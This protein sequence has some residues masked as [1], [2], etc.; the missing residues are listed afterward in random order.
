M[1]K[2]RGPLLALGLLMLLMLVLTERA[3]S[4]IETRT[5]YHIRFGASLPTTCKPTTGDVF[6]KTAAT[7]GVYSC[8]ATD[9]WTYQG[10]GAGGPPTG[11]AGGDLAGTYPNPTL[12]STG[13]TPATYGSATQAVVIVVDAKGR[14]TGASNVTISGVA[15]GG[16]A[17]GELTGNYPNPTLTTSGASAGTYGAAT[18]AIVATVDAKGR[19]TNVSEVTITGVVPG[20]AA[21]GDLTGTYPNPTL[22][23]SGVVAGTYGSA[24]QVPVV[25]VDAKGRITGVSNVTISGVAPGGA[26]GGQ[27]AGTYPNPTLSAATTGGRVI[28]ASGAGT[29][30][31]QSNFTYTNGQLITNATTP[32]EVMGFRVEQ[33][34]K[35][36]N[37]WSELVGR[38]AGDNRKAA[39]VGT[40]GLGTVW[41]AG[42]ATPGT[43]GTRILWVTSTGVGAGPGNALPSGTFQVF[44]NTATTG[45]TVH[46]IKA[47]AGQSTNN[48]LEILSNADVVLTFID[49]SG[50]MALPYIKV[51]QLGGSGNQFVCVDNNGLL[52]KSG[53]ACL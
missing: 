34:N 49:S 50:G 18:K 24:T 21:G 5:A 44:D 29:I 51:N 13:V 45:I 16:A 23:A 10:T 20:G 42:G 48:L 35:D 2:L 25:V 38:D 52:Y 17:G 26:A 8:T 12:G 43:M 1:K 4:Q 36:S 30:A 6:F 46:K 33:T 40:S 32:G 15:P 31:E 28:T 37:V 41:M 53:A 7:V 27:L 9:T 22:G 11:A 19:I 14:I 39:Q 3:G 47:G